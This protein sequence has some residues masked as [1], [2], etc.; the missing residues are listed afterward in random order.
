MLATIRPALA[1]LLHP[2]LRAGLLA[3]ALAMLTIS[4]VVPIAMLLSDNREQERRQEQASIRANLAL[5]AEV[6]KPFGTQW[7]LEGDTLRLGD[8]TMNGRHDLV[9]VVKRVTGGVATIFAGEVRV[10]TNVMRPDGTRAVGAPIGPG[11]VRDAVYGRGER[12]EG[13]VQILGLPHLGAYEP[14]KDANGRVIGMI[15]VAVSLAEADARADALM[16]R[17]LLAAGLTL[18][19]AGA[20]LWWLLRRSLRPLQGL[21]AAL[22]AITA[23]KLDADVPCTD[24]HDELGDIGRAVAALRD[25]TAVAQAQARAAEADRQEAQ[26]GRIAARAA[27]AGQLEEAVGAI[28]AEL[29]TSATAL[30][31]A[32]ETVGEAGTRTASRAGQSAA[33]IS[34]ATGN[35]NAVAAAAEELAV[36]VAEIT[37]QVAE[38]ARTAQEAASAARASDTTV[39]S[40]AEAAT[41]IGDV[42]RLISDIAGQTNL[43]ALNATIEAARAGEAG[44]GFAVV[45][46]EVKALAAQTG[47]ATEEIASQ[48]G[49][50]RG[51]TDQAVGAVRGIADAVSRMEEVTSSIAAAVEEQGAA[52]REIARNAAEAAAGTQDAAADINSLTEEVAAGAAGITTLREAGAAVGRQGSA[53]RTEVASFA[54]RLRAA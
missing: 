23:G 49:A 48:I 2:S 24:R 20:L 10:A 15:G 40:L 54:N 7:R 16:Q 22:R 5:L 38:S 37:R 50:M 45:A 4:A 19:L 3:V 12:Y 47:R 52:T 41:R 31:N 13:R 11:P 21:S 29:G 14:V 26:A 8:T 1:R 39:A 43:L 51:A 33:R 32:A 30:L 42:V 17:A 44:K 35:V 27:T 53:L 9:D 36:S 46:Q 25:A 18:V 34:Q 28:A 6:V